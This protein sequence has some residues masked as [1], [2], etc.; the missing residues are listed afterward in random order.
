MLHI[1][2]H[3]PPGLISFLSPF[4]G[5]FEMLMFIFSSTFYNFDPLRSWGLKSQT[6]K[7]FSEPPVQNL[8]PV[9]PIYSARAYVFLMT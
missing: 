3:T 8:S 1:P 6:N 7:W 2:M 5:F 9:A 4:R